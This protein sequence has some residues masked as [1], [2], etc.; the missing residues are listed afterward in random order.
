MEGTIVVSIPLSLLPSLPPFPKAR[1]ISP[2]L[3]VSQDTDAS[4]LGLGYDLQGFD[5]F[6]NV[7]LDAA[8]EVSLKGKSE[9][10]ELGTSFTFVSLHLSLSFP[11]LS[12]LSEFPTHLGLLP[13]HRPNPAQ[14]R[15]HNAHPTHHSIKEV[16]IV[17]TFSLFPLLF[18]VNHHPNP[19]PRR[20]YTH[21]PPT[22]PS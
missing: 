16:S 12:F 6:M 19:N 22:L 15:Q 4:H 1:R 8:A 13:S 7:V 2:L 21:L 11:S 10:K 5:E 20:H 18:L 9:R 3:L 14:G 17:L